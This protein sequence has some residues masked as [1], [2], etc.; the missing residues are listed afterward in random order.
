MIKSGYFI[1]QGFKVKRIFIVMILFLSVLVVYITN[2]YKASSKKAIPAVAFLSLTSV[3]DQT[4]KGFKEQM[5]QYGWIENTNIKYIVSKPAQKVENL[6]PMVKSIIDKK[7]D[8]ILVSST[9]AT[10]EVKRATEKNNI[11]VV[12]CPVN[13]PVDSNIVLNPKAPEKNITGIRLPIGDVKRFEWLHL[14]APLGKRILIPFTNS[15]SSSMI[16]REKVKNIAMNL[17]LTIVEKEFNGDIKSYLNNLPKDIDAIFLPRDSS[18]EAKIDDFVAYAN[19]HKL[20]L[21]VP[22]Y[23]QVEKGALFTYGFIHFELGRDAAKMVDRILKGLK[24]IDVPVKTGSAH[25]V[26]NEETAKKLGLA[27]PTKAVRNAY[28]IIH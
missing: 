9:P 5:V 7:P 6:K 19:K 12:F 28:K 16:S 1:K 2:N 18:V 22:S 10:Q 26:I 13:D 15:D 25:L 17:G 23:Q 14:I 20:P 24:P 8:L 3:D 11:P 4:F 21:C 27:I